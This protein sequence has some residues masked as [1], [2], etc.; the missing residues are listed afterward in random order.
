MPPNA[1]VLRSEPA[2]VP[3]RDIE[4]PSSRPTAPP[5]ATVEPMLL[6]PERSQGM[7]FGR[8]HL[9]DAGTTSPFDAVVPGA[10]LRIPFETSPPNR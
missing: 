10:R 1:S 8:E 9:R 4:A 2:P 5:A 3:N 6:P 7:T